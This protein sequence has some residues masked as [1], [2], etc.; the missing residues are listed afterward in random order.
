VLHGLLIGLR[1]L[2][3]GSGRVALGG[4]QIGMAQQ[5]ADAGQ[6]H[7]GFGDLP[8]KGMPQPVRAH[9]YPRLPAIAAQLPGQAAH[10]QRLAARI[11]KH[12][13]GR[14]RRPFGQPGG[15]HRVSIATQQDHPFLAAFAAHPYPRRL[16][17]RRR[18]EHI[19]HPQADR[20]AHPQTGAPQQHK[21]S[22]VAGAAHHRPQP[23]HLGCVQVPRQGLRLLAGVAFEAHRVGPGQLAR[24][25]GQTIEERLEG[26]HP[27][28]DRRR[29]AAGLT[30]PIHKGVDILHRHVA[31]GAL[32]GSCEQAHVTQVI[33]R[34]APTRKT[35]LQIA[36]ET[37]N[38]FITVHGLASGHD[39]R[40][41]ADS[42]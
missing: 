12:G 25:F 28:L 13:R 24:L 26:G 3:I 9:R 11:H 35:P 27:A 30:L 37:E 33:N 2:R 20:F 10:T 1:Q 23:F 6:R 18:A 7:A 15:Q 38:G 39:Y 42:I 5:L 34:R 40:P 14:L 31:P 29:A 36:F 16:V 22:P 17:A 8:G 32:T 41:V 4:G 19:P 21:P